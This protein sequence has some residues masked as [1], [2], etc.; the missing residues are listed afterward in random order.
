MSA[1]AAPTRTA[2]L[3]KLAAKPRLVMHY[4]AG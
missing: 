2:P 4:E 1:G 3:A